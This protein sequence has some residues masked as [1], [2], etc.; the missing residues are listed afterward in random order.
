PIAMVIADTEQVAQYAAGLIQVE[1]E[2]LAVVNTPT[3]AFEA[4]APLVHEHLGTYKVMVKGLQAKP[5]TNIA[6]HTKIRKGNFEE[7]WQAADT[8]IEK[9]FSFSPSDHAALETRVARVE[10]LPDGRVLVYTSTQGPFYV[11]KLMSQFLGIDMGKI[12]VHTTVIGGAFG[13]KGTVQL[14]FLAYLASRAVGGRTVKIANTREEDMITSPV[15]IGLTAHV[16]LAANRDGRIQAA[17]YEYYFDGGAYSDTGA[18]ISKAAAADCTGPYHIENV[19][20]DSY[21]MYTNHPYATSFRGFGHPELTFAVERTMD[22]LAEKLAIDPF[23]IRMRNAI[24]PG[25]TTPTQV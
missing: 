25:H 14:E 22:M 11:R 15:H 7:A 13:G 3:E 12:S 17:K 9:R 18:G 1:Y 5:K 23:E 4:D 20:C 6:N 2:P 21:C 24:Q 10:I 16:K 8:T 19:H